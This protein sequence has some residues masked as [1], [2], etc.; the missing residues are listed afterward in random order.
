MRASLKLPAGVT[1]SSHVMLWQWGAGVCESRTCV[2][3]FRMHLCARVAMLLQMFV[4][5]YMSVSVF[6]CECHNNSFETCLSLFC[7]HTSVSLSQMET[8]FLW[9]ADSKPPL[10]FT[11]WKSSVSHSSEERSAWSSISFSISFSHLMFEGQYLGWM[12]DAP[13]HRQGGNSVYLMCWMV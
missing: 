13:S 5:S 4:C 8:S 11:S 1:H 7:V 10:L 12:V 3:V 2:C 9:M 6:I